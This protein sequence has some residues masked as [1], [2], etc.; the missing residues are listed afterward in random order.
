MKILFLTQGTDVM[1]ASRFRIFQFLKYFS[2]A[3][4]SFTVMTAVTKDQY[5]TFIGSHGIIAKI[6]WFFQLL[7][8]RFRCLIHIR[9]YDVVVLQRET[10]P[11]LYPFM[12]VLITSL[13]K[14]CIFDMDDAIFS[15]RND[16][17]RWLRCFVP[18]DF[19][20]FFLRRCNRVLVANEYLLEYARKHCQDVVIIPTCVD[21]SEYPVDEKKY[22][23]DG[24]VQIGWIG[25]PS[26]AVY[27]KIVE[28][29][30]Q[31]LAQQVD[32]IFIVIGVTEYALKGVK[33]R[34]AGWQRQTEIRDIC[35][36]D[37]GIMPLPDDEWTRGK[38]GTKILQYMAAGVPSIAADI[39]ANKKI[40]TDGVNGFL[41]GSEQEWFDKLILLIS[42]VELR[43]K[44][45]QN[46][47]NSITDSYTISA[48]LNNW[49]SAITN[50]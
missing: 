44:M 40:I 42:N 23:S 30:L 6:R 19:P 22:Q 8:G 21:A 24:P 48:W 11:L 39:G 2:F 18:D 4:H 43:K 16:R 14:K 35:S 9:K 1:P 17:S 38:S 36:F 25:S 49:L 47:R 29:V 45:G 33:T 41:A 34:A 13:A 7:R 32:F 5:E 20:K 26:T 3:D 37:I 31:R 27:L 50:L 46:G 15:Y 12:D 10:W 28:P